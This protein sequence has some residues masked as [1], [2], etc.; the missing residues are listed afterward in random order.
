MSFCNHTFKRNPQKWGCW[1]CA[2]F[3]VFIN[4]CSRCS[5][6]SGCTGLPHPHLQPPIAPAASPGLQRHSHAPRGRPV[7]LSPGPSAAHPQGP[8]PLLPAEALVAHRASATSFRVHGSRGRAG[9]HP[10]A[11]CSQRPRGPT[12]P[13]CLLAPEA[14]PCPVRGS[15]VQYMLIVVLQGKLAAAQAVGS[16]GATWEPRAPLFPVPP[17]S[18]S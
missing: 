2:V 1:V 5:L 17:L 7:P 3:Q 8:E 16:A 15:I 6:P 10:Q 18:L 9:I 13:R 14:E 12:T 11:C 4:S